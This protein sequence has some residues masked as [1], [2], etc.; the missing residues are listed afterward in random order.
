METHKW[1][2]YRTQCKVKCVCPSGSRSVKVEKKNQSDKKSDCKFVYL[3]NQLFD[4]Q[5]LNHST[6]F[7]PLYIYTQFCFCALAAAECDETPSLPLMFNKCCCLYQAHL[8]QFISS[9]LLS[10]ICFFSS[11]HSHS[12]NVLTLNLISCLSG[13][14][15]SRMPLTKN[16]TNR[17]QKGLIVLHQCRIGILIYAERSIESQ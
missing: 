3:V 10:I 4:L 9:I 12:L 16:A 6:I 7:E 17:M 1:I 15:T 11:S 5:E 14:I 2:H 13:C 8:S